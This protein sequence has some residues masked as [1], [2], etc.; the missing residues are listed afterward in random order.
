MIC[1]TAKYQY[2]TFMCNHV[3]VHWDFLFCHF[4]F[5]TFAFYVKSSVKMDHG[6]Y[7]RT[8]HMGKAICSQP[9]CQAKGV[10][11]RIAFTTQSRN[12]LKSHYEHVSKLLLVPAPNQGSVPGTGT[13]TYSTS[14]TKIIHIILLDLDVILNSVLWI[15]NDIFQIRIQLWIFQFPD[16][17]PNK[18]SGSMRIWIQAILFKY[19]YRYQYPIFRNKI[20]TP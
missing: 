7:T 18:S 11:N 9:L 15:Q 12:P 13:G 20:K 16:L 8:I 17:D 2:L 4:S 10:K 5:Y 6:K 1:T 14:G 19:R 3:T